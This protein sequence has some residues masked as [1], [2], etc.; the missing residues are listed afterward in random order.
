MRITSFSIANKLFGQ[1]KKYMDIKYYTLMYVAPEEG[2]RIS[3]RIYSQNEKTD[4][5]V[6]GCCALDK[7]LKINAMGGGNSSYQ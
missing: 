6:K 1:T 4:L 7:S 2:R 3:R 5:Y